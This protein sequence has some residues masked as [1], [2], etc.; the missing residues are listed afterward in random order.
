MT[1]CLNQK[2]N[3]LFIQSNW[4]TRQITLMKTRLP[5]VSL[6]FSL[7]LQKLHVSLPPTVDFYAKQQLGRT[8][9][10]QKRGHCGV[11]L[12]HCTQMFDESGENTTEK[13]CIINSIFNFPDIN[14]NYHFISRCHLCIQVHSINVL[15]AI[16]YAYLAVWVA[17][18][19]MQAI[20]NM[21]THGEVLI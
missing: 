19:L 3:P 13:E 6:F 2:I 11:A 10:R 17:L 12:L 8:Y 7:H 15:A 14:M 1:F 4:M 5:F 18:L 9:G 16:S 21:A 20:N